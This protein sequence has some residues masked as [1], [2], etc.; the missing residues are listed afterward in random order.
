MI[1]VPALCI[2]VDCGLPSTYVFTACYVLFCL[3]DE[4]L[5][6]KDN[7]KSLHTKDDKHNKRGDHI[8]A[9]SAKSAAG[10]SADGEDAAMLMNRN[11]HLRG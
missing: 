2:T 3:T 4:T 9:N 1:P 10:I 7:T 5:A 11:I 8:T 6:S